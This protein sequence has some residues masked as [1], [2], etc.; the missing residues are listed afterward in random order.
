MSSINPNYAVTDVH[1]SPNYDAGRPAGDPTGIVIHWWG[2]PEWG[3]TH[4]QVVD[5]LTNGNRSNPTSAHYVVS[6]G[7]ITQLV[8][9][10]DRAWHCYGNNLRTIGIECH[11][12]ATDGDLR[13]VARLIAAIRSE[14]GYLPLSRHCDHFATACPG[15]YKDKLDTL[16][17]LTTHEGEN[18][19]QL[20]DEITRP[21][22]HSG[23]VGA[24]IGWMDMRIEKFEQLLLSP[25][26]KRATDGSVSSEQTDAATELEWIGANFARVYDGIN[27]LS[28]RLDDL[29]RLIEA[30]ATK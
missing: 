9:D 10:N 15:N 13:T 2:L 26:Y 25:H 8:S 6:D 1:P 14:W 16:E 22:G 17:Y 20:N 7:R 23:S 21:D 11:P 24:M 28:K 30:G 18:D 29:A 27:A 3:Q 19:M 12:A 4:D 5:F